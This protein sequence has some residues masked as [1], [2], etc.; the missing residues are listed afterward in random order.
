MSNTH[1]DSYESR[2]SGED[3]AD[4]AMQNYLKK[5]ELVEYKDYL[6]IGTDPKINKLDLFWYATEILLLPDYIVVQ[7]GHIFFVEVK[8]TKRLKATDYYKIQEMDWKGSKYKEVKVGL[9][10]F[11]NKNAEP[12]WY[13]ANVLVDI[14]KDPDIPMK[15]YPEL[16][17]KGNKKAYKEIPYQ[18]L[19]SYPA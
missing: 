15:Y 8:G 14:W 17:F 4:I 11:S 2:N 7:K 3:M 12:K 1:K 5:I 19:L 18:N 13:P 6:R 9:M 16:D 10:Y